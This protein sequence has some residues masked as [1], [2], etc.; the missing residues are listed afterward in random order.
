MK[1]WLTTNSMIAPRISI[2]SRLS[3]TKAGRTKRRPK[4]YISAV[5]TTRLAQSITALSHAYAVSPI[6]TPRLNTSA[7]NTLPRI[8]PSP[9]STVAIVR[10]KKPQ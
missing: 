4:A 8:P 10:T 2:A 7:V 1:K 9:R 6:S 3:G 5:N